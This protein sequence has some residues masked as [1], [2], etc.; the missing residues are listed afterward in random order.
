MAY[1]ID[2]VHRLE[3]VHSFA[4]LARGLAAEVADP[5]WFLGRQWQLGEH[6]GEDAASPVR[7]EYRTGLVPVDLF[8]GDPSL[9]PQRVPAEAIVEAEP[10]DFW[11]PG[12]RVAIGRAV[13]Q[14]AATAGRPLPADEE[15]LRLAGLPVPYD[16]LDGTGFDGLTL[17]TDRDALGL[18]DDWFPERPADPPPRDLWD[19]AELVYQADFTA[20][21][22]GL[23]LR[24]HDGGDLDWWSVDATRPLP[25]PDPA[26]DPVSVLATRVRY[27]GAPN[28]RWWQIE[29]T[30]TDLGAYAPDRSHFATLLLLELVAS[31]TDDW[32]TF[33]VAAAAGHV[34]TLHE[35][36]VVDAFGDR[37]PVRPPAD[38]WSLFAVTGLGR[39]SLVLWPAVT[40]PLAGPVTDQVDLGVDEDANL[41]W[42]VERRVAGRDLPSPERPPP[43]VTQQQADA[44][45]QPRYA[46]RPSTEVPPFWHPYLIE[47]DGPR[48]RLVQGRLADLSGATAVLTPEPV[49]DLL[50]DPASGGRHPVHQLEPSAVPTD[51]LQIERRHLLGR[52]TDG[53]PV[54]WTQRRR[55]PLGAAPTMRLQFDVIE[56]A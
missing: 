12:R 3:P 13:E 49:S 8:D 18:E 1:R 48:R 14:A 29:E 6:Q 32:F 43:P 15:R 55:V 37:W 54:L 24:R 20:G 39:R 21:P 44:T 17:F 45:T 22:T 52:R 23:T 42:A 11:T 27:P 2:A 7:V 4:D 51:G 28:P 19:P 56:P 41:V 35:V 40:T 5:V 9:D 26:P 34:L 16:V 47:E 53:L 50:R 10:D 31:H 46:Y 36:V 33:P 30:R 38:D 25:A